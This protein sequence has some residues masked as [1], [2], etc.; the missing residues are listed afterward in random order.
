M[1]NVPPHLFL[2]SESLPRVTVAAHEA[3]EKLVADTGLDR[4]A[5]LD[6]AIRTADPAK[7]R[8]QFA[9]DVEDVDRWDG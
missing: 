6:L 9:T 2:R 3:L 5:A 8:E 7:I 4:R 1:K